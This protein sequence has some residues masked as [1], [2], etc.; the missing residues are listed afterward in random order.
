LKKRTLDCLVINNLAATMSEQ[1]QT[2]RGAF[3]EGDEAFPGAALRTETHIQIA[4]RE[5]QC[6]L[7]IFR[8]TAVLEKQGES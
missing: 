3:E 8:P 6:M 5:R 7:G 2:V 4:V 1:I